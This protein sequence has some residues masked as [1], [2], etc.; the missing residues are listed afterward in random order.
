MGT[1]Q[2]HLAEAYAK[3]DERYVEIEG[4]MDLLNDCPTEQELRDRLLHACLQS[5]DL[6]QAKE[7]LRD[8]DRTD[9]RN[10]ELP[11]VLEEMYKSRR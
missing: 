1:L 4:W 6:E 2:T 3:S 7:V 5:D 11:S 8:L 10:R 9:P